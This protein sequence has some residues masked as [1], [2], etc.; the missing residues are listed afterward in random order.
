MNEALSD[1]ES[2]VPKVSARDFAVGI[3]GTQLWPIALRRL[4]LI[5]VAYGG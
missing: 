2:G 4:H 5:S 3:D 1:I